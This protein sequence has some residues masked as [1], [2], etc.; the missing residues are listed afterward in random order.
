MLSESV[1]DTIISSKNGKILNKNNIFYVINNEEKEKIKYTFYSLMKENVNK[2]LSYKNQISLLHGVIESY[3]NGDTFYEAFN[4]RSDNKHMQ[5]YDYF[6]KEGEG[7]KILEVLNSYGFGAD[8]LKGVSL[9]VPFGDGKGNG[10]SIGNGLS[11]K[12][13]IESPDGESPYVSVF[14]IRY[15]NEIIYQWKGRAKND[16]DAFSVINPDLEKPVQSKT[17]SEYL[18]SAITGEGEYPIKAWKSK[19][20][21]IFYTQGRIRIKKSI[22]E[23]YF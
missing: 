14:E 4:F 13:E 20:G 6:L 15:N 12:E 22:A 3:S 7:Q 21:Q 17:K 16:G 23:R 10:Q 18:G 9:G 11:V 8:V 5:G 19:N 2:N 1:I